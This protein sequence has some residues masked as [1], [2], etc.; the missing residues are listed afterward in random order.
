MK[1]APLGNYVILKQADAEETTASGI[2]L[3]GHTAERPQYATVI[4][5]GPDVNNV[6]VNDKVI[7]SKYAGTQV[8]IKKETCIVI[9]N[10]VILAVIND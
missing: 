3:P 6:S 5:I 4:A 1:L 7:Y 2:I 8:E 10:N 9:K